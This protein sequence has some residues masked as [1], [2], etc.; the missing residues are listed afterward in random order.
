[1]RLFDCEPLAIGVGEL[2]HELQALDLM[3]ASMRHVVALGFPTVLPVMDA[4]ALHAGSAPA[5]SSM[6]S[7]GTAL[8]SIGYVRLLPRSTITVLIV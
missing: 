2:E 1:M 5:L 6:S 3:L 7:A 4:Q 8:T